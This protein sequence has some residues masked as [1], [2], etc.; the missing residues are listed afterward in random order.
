[1]A[2]TDPAHWF[3][4][5]SVM[6]DFR[7]PVFTSDNKVEALID[8]KAY[9]DHLFDR[10]TAMV[11]GDFY[12]F[13]AWRVTSTMSLKPDVPGTKSYGQML[14]DLI[15]A[16][17]DVRGMLWYV[18]TSIRYRLISNTHV[19]E[20]I[21]TINLLNAGGTQRGVYD[22]RLPTFIAS[23]HQ[24]TSILTSGGQTWAYVGGIDI[25]LDRWDTPAHGNP[26]ARPRENFDGWHD[27]QAV[28][29]GPAVPQVYGNFLSRWNDPTPPHTAPGVPG[30]TVPPAVP[31][32][33]P[34]PP[35]AGTHHVQLLRTLACQATYPW[36]SGGEQTV[37]LAYEK[38]IDLAQHYIYIE[39]QY[40]WSCSLADKLKAAADR[41]VK[42]IFVLAHK[43]DMTALVNF[44]N[45]LRHRQFLKI[46]RSGAGAANVSVFHLQRPGDGADIYVH[47]KTMVV[48]DCIAFIGSSNIG[49][50]SHTSDSELHL[51]VVDAA[52][53]SS[54][55]NGTATTVC[56]F[57]R[58]YRVALWREH[59]GVA[60]GLEDPIA[61]LASWPN[62]GT[63]Q[64]HHAVLH[65]TPSILLQWWGV[66]QYAMN[67]HTKCP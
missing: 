17:V 66:V 16:G 23:H 40:A 59:L 13:T 3:L 44:A 54:P 53:I 55:M 21:A 10:L 15:Q 2:N 39:E 19:G 45:D 63:T 26:P 56:K 34:V 52:T 58:D 33:L 5:A 37:R 49:L 38:A 6:S 51:G 29:Q 61:G 46:V 47:A 28:L 1:M 60:A 67:L 65:P 11:A 31:M 57:A 30:G 41:G 25:A 48:D 32:A 62:A 8:G 12:Y 22:Q 7:T 24:K 36:L 42:V 64:V 14:T 4:E 27:V 35:A 43:Y 18:A 20:N 9:M 50:R